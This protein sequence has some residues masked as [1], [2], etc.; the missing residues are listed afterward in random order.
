LKLVAT[1]NAGS[2]VPGFDAQFSAV[3]LQVDGTG[4]TL[5]CLVPTSQTTWYLASFK[6]ESSGALQFL[7]TSYADQ[8]SGQIRFVQNNQY[9]LTDGCYNTEPDAS[10]T[11]DSND[12]NDIV[13]YKR[14]SNGFLTYIGT[15]N[16]TPAAQSPYEYC[17][18]VNASDSSNHLAVAFTTFNPPGD[19]IESPPYSLGTYTVNAEGA[20]STT[21]S[22]E[23]MAT[24]SLGE[25]VNGISIDP[26]GKLLAAGGV[27]GF[28]LFHFNGAS[29]MTTYTGN[30]DQNNQVR[31]LSW[32]KSS[33]LYLL[34]SHSVDIYQ[35]T[36]TTNT[37]LKPWEF[38]NPYSMIVLSM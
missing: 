6:I 18:G 30:L 37:E 29:P 20:P 3:V 19:D 23:N 13:E 26:T 21:S 27:D 2:Y 9:A 1:T 28:Q 4:S 31:A 38:T 35:V 7:G 12:V 34:T 22:Y 25:Y 11:T 17:A 10:F 16:D 32:D 15:S 8:Y 5:Y 36:P 24:T 33:H 14:E